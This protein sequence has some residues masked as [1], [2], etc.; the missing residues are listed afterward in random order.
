LA[1]FLVRLAGGETTGGDG[2]IAGVMAFDSEFS[3]LAAGGSLSPHK[4]SGA[5]SASVVA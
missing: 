5:V 4:K 2:G 3:A 1:A